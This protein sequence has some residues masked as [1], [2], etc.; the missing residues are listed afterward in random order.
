[1]RG[2]HNLYENDVEHIAG[3]LQQIETFGGGNTIACILQGPFTAYQQTKVREQVMI[4][5]QK[6]LKAMEWLKQNNHLYSNLH[7]PTLEELPKPIIID[8][9][10][11]VESENTQIESRFEYTVVFPATEEID[12]T[13]GGNMTQDAFKCQV[14]QNMERSNTISVYSRSTQNRLRDYEGDNLAL[15]FPL[16]FPYG[17]GK[18]SKF[19]ESLNQKRATNVQLD[20]ISHLQRMSI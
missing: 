15:T 1:M 3:A 19:E 6:I 7:I 14:L 12:T 5:P 18:V 2:W 11:L 16:Q 10:N 20:Y 4:R 13:N 8:D 17:L 9:S